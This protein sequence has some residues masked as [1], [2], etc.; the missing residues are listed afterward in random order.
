MRL[1]L[2]A[3]SFLLVVAA[4]PAPDPLL[5]QIVAGARAVPPASARWERALKQSGQEAGDSRT[6]S[7][8]RTERWDGKQLT[9]VNVDGKP[10]TADDIASHRKASAGRPLPGYHRVADYFGTGATRSQ[11]AQGRMFYRVNGLPK[12]SINIGRDISGSLVAEAL[13]DNSGPQPFVSRLRITLPKP[14]GFMFVA[15]LDSFEAVSEYRLVGGRP[16]LV[17]QTQV[18]AGKQMGKSGTSRSESLYTI[19]G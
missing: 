16:M 9:L 19:L 18:V 12:G 1:V 5:Q 4:A 8:S 6:E 15:R 10:P 14:L 13:I 3:L 7:H 2:A 17:R 11:D